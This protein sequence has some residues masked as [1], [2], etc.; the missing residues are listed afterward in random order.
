MSRMF[1]GLLM[2]CFLVAAEGFAYAQEAPY[3]FRVVDI[4]LQFSFQGQ[5]QQDI[6]R[7]TDINNN[8]E[9]IGNDFAGDGFTIGA[10]LV[11]IWGFSPRLVLRLNRRSA[12]SWE[13]QGNH[14]QDDENEK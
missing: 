12:E 5:D 11:L 8:G 1:V 13:N 9:W 2:G 14:K 6:V 3:K 7:F 4:P 10:S